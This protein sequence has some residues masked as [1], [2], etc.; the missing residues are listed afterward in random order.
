[1]RIWKRVIF[2][3]MR[4]FQSDGPERSKLGTKAEIKNLNSLRFLQRAVEH[5]IDRQI[6]LIESGDRVVQ[7]TRLWNE[8]EAR[9]YAM[10]SKEDAHDY[11][12]F[13]EPDLPPLEVSASW[14]ESIRG[15]LPELPEARRFRFM[16]EYGLSAD[17]AFT[18]T[19]RREL[20]DY[21]ET[22]VQCIRR[23]ASIC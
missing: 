2:G 17:E 4:T 8:K 23:C 15:T 20:A 16:R 21:Y 18:M 6:A 9:T 13:P 11:R 12:Y 7:E 22:V 10:R 5:E 3:A 1:M 14:I 19:G